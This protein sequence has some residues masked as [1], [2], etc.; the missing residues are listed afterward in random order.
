MFCNAPTVAY[1]FSGTNPST[2][3]PYKPFGYKP[4]VDDAT[5]SRELKRTLPAGYERLILPCNRCLLCTARYRKMWSLR[6]MHELRGYDQACYLTLT[7][8]EES[9]SDIFPPL[10][11]SDWNSLRHKPFQDFMKRLRIRLERG[12]EWKKSRPLYHGEGKPIRYYMCGEYGDEFHRPHYHAII[13]GVNPPDLVPIPYKPHLFTSQLFSST[14]PFGFHTVGSVTPETVS[15]VAGYV[16]KKLD[17]SRSTVAF[18]NKVNPEYVAMSRG[19]KKLGTGGIGKSFFDRFH[20]SD[21]YPENSDGTFVRTCALDRK[22]YFV[23]MPKYYDE[24]LRLHDPS[25]Y[26]RMLAARRV[27]AAE[28]ETD[29]E[30]WLSTSHLKHA[31]SVE[32]RK[33]REVGAVL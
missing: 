20:D 19:S 25:K 5:F 3:K 28:L 8:N 29:Y 13:F 30:D 21:L 18:L 10:E 11:G 22:G 14:W 31:V 1:R 7:V 2:G 33:K 17:A 12:Y 23:K 16:D 15:Y 26:D 32:R 4:F 27:G 9:L 24:L 6:C